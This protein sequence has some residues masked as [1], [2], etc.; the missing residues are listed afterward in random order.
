MNTMS[1]MVDYVN[2]YQTLVGASVTQDDIKKASVLGWSIEWIQASFLVLDDIMDQSLTR[3]GQPCW[4]KLPKVGLEA[5][6]DGLLLEGVADRLLRLYFSSNEKL[7]IKLRHLFDDIKFKTQVGQLLDTSAG[8]DDPL[9]F[10]HDRYDRIVKYKTAY[11]TFYLPFMSAVVLSQIDFNKQDLDLIESLALA[12]GFY[13]QI[14]DDYLDCYG[15]PSVTGKIGTDIQDKKCSWLA[16]TFLEKASP[17]ERAIFAENYGQHNE[18]KIEKIKQIYEAKGLK[19]LFEDFE[20]SSFES[21]TQKI[22]SVVPLIL[23][24]HV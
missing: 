3:R 2:C 9:T 5:V 11:Y 16:V 23:L 14:Q 7:Y 20:R 13:F 24:I 21:V 6:N 1:L 12:F 10:T 8:E 18:E 4:Y 22:N 19:N 15:D 17:E